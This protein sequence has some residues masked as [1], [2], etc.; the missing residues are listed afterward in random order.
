MRLMKLIKIPTGIKLNLKLNTSSLLMVVSLLGAN[1]FALSAENTGEGD[2]STATAPQ[3]TITG[4]VT[5]SSGAPLP[6]VSI[7]IE[8][9]TTGTETDFDGNFSVSA[10]RGQTLVFSFIGM[11]TVSV[12]VADQTTLSIS[13]EDDASALEEVVVTGYGT[14]KRTTLTGAVST[15]TGD[16]LEKSAAP[17]M[18]NALA[19][20]VAGLYI[21]TGNN[22]PGR[23][24][25]GIRVRG[26]NTF[27]NSGA[28]V[29]IDGI[30]NRA[31]GLARLNPADIASISILKDASAAIYGARAAN[32]VILVTTKRG[33]KGPA[34][35]KISS[36]YGVQNLYT[37]PDM[38]TGAE[39]M[40]LINVLNVYK[41]PTGEW[42]AAN[43]A[44]GTP[45]TRPNGEVLN[46]SY[47]SDRIANT[48]AGN[49]PWNFPDTDWMDEVITENAPIM[50]HNAQISGGS[51]DMT[52]L[53]SVSYLE[54][55]I[56]FKG[57]PEGYKQFDMRVNID[58]NISDHLKLNMGLYSRQEDNRTAT[59]QNVINDL[60]RQYPWF[61]AYWPT[62]EFGP[63][64]ENG[65]N[66]AIR[67]TDEP[68]YTE[69]NRNY[70]QSNI[71][72]VFKVP[73]VEGLELKADYSYDKFNDEYT[74][75]NQPWTLYTW[76]GVNQDSSGL[77]GA[78]RGPQNPDLTE[79]HGTRTDQTATFNASY[80]KQ[81]GNHF[82]K[83]LGG[84]TRE[85]S[86]FDSFSAFRKDFLSSEIDK[87][88][89]GG[90]DGQNSTGT[91]S[92][93][94]RLNY[95]GRANYTFK[96]KYL[97]EVLFRYDGS[98]L[99]PESDRY[100]FFPGVSGGWILTEEDFFKEA[101]PIFDFLKVRASY[102]EMGNDHT[103]AF[104]YSAG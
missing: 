92:E 16:A 40:D 95:Y 51:D 60:I 76:D 24:T 104:Q 47:S 3:Q 58:A 80:E 7:L 23:E 87:L 75:W 33:K 54:Q 70:V 64:I 48:A 93:T 89:F 99:F 20:K 37:T 9:T 12:V 71:G 103:D 68:G 53:G 26:T 14:Q 22:L 49:D 25:N 78:L 97:L 101:L 50:R 55:D 90:N 69:T 21:D 57:A 6:G 42:D 43:A 83:L 79:Y 28:L 98:Y 5:D 15:V 73:G 35:V 77:T 86:Q 59:N 52:Y 82:V 100:G 13:L 66:P 94:A 30:P 2:A 10:D 29:V 31:G 38:L 45:F 91:G 72:L 44:R 102:G 41:L 65:N 36:T 85:E 67:V 62:G 88:K 4:T 11:T 18:G 34:K 74:N 39:Y 81:I 8:G 84:I 17:N 61:P 32:G 46:P 1:G 19:G 27:N 56:N 96:D 63:D